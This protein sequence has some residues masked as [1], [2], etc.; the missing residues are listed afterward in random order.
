MVTGRQV[1]GARGLLGMTQEELSELSGV[2]MQTIKDFEHSA[3][4]PQLRTIKDLQRALEEKGIAFLEDGAGGVG[5]MLK[6]AAASS[7]VQG[8]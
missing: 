5:V 1:R 3:R 7:P 2:S 8:T 6:G 4:K